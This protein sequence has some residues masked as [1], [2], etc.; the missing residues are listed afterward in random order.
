VSLRAQTDLCR[1]GR[2]A[3]VAGCVVALAL[4]VSL[5]V[6]LAV[7]PL[8]G[9]HE[10]VLVRLETTVN[11][12]TDPPASLARLP[13]IGLTRARAVV[14]YRRQRQQDGS[15]AFR[16]PDDLQRVTGIG[17]KTVEGIGPWLRFDAETTPV[18]APSQGP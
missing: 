12:N 6:G 1:S 18:P 3:S 7:A 14:N 10:R 5:A 13:R 11:P 15:V 8:R 17:P 2:D 9:A 4:G 16:E